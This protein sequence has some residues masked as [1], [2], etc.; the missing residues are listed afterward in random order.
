MKGSLSEPF[1]SATLVA[2]KSTGWSFRIGLFAN[3]FRDVVVELLS[4]AIIEVDH[5]SSFVP[6]SDDVVSKLRIEVESV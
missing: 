4:A 1:N 2:Y 6:S 3:E 5:V